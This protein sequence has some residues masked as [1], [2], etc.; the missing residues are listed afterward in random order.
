LSVLAELHKEYF[1]GFQIFGIIKETGVDDEGLIEFHQKYFTYPLFRD[2]SYS[3]YSALGDRKVGLSIFW[4][5]LSI[6]SMICDA[7][8]RIREKNIGGNMKGEGLVQGGII[9][10]GR[11]G[12][13]KCMY[14]EETGKDLPMADICSALNAVREQ[15]HS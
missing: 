14:E 6:V 10:F 5:P 2:Q 4:N 8:Q 13:P 15:Q 12:E 1:D 7:Y 11:D 9:I 3:F